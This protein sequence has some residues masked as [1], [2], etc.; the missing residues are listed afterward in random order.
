ML[1][2]SNDKKIAVWYGYGLAQWIFIAAKWGLGLSS[3]SWVMVLSISWVPFTGFLGVVVLGCTYD[4]LLAAWRWM[5][6][7]KDRWEL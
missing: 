3:V 4:V 1:E 2:L 7:H 6:G 5:F